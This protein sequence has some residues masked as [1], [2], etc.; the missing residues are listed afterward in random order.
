MGW[1]TPWMKVTPRSMTLSA[2]H[3]GSRM[4]Q[5]MQPRAG[6]SPSCSLGWLCFYLCGGCTDG[7][8]VCVGVCHTR[9]SPSVWWFSLQLKCTRFRVSFV[10]ALSSTHSTP[11]CDSP[12]YLQR[13]LSAL[14]MRHG[15]GCARC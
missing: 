7:G 3:T 4:R 9:T 14:L 2:Q 10:P 1:M 8:D 11:P 5:A 15:V 6:L 13:E 12:A